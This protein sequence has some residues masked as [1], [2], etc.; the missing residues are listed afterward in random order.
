VKKHVISLAPLA[1][2]LMLA[3]DRGS[4]PNDHVEGGDDLHVPEEAGVDCEGEGDDGWQTGDGTGETGE[5]PGDGDC[6]LGEY[7]AVPYDEAPDW[8][9]LSGMVN[10]SVSTDSSFASQF[11][12]ARFYTTDYVDDSVICMESIVEPTGIDSCWVWYTR[13]EG[14]GNPSPDNWYE[15][16]PVESVTF[17]V[18]DGPIPLDVTAATVLSPS[19]YSAELPFDGVPFGDVASMV[20]TFDGLPALAFDLAVPSDILPLGYALDTAMLDSEQLSSWTWSS[21]GGAAPM[22]LQVSLGAT[23]AGTGW[24]ELVRIQCEVTDDGEFA[25]P[26]DYIDLAHERLGP[27]LYA[28]VSLTRETTGTK[29]LAGKQLLWRSN[30]TAWLGLELVD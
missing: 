19:W 5:T 29:M 20:A 12:D 1:A 26:V 23:P 14:L 25:F 27:E 10:H 7:V 18:G 17:D 22:K 15:D 30:V 8:S 21:P 2:L 13:G 24:T 6:E 9:N 28:S 4:M 3:C 11:V 16:L